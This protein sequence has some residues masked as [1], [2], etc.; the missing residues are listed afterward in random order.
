MDILCNLLLAQLSFG[1]S[2]LQVKCLEVGLT[3]ESSRGCFFHYAGIAEILRSAQND[4]RK[5]GSAL[6]GFFSERGDLL[7]SGMAV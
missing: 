5:L 7:L 6:P 3:G 4:D 1:M 2:R